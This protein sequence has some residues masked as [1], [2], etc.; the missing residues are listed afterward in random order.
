MVGGRVASRG[1]WRRRRFH[2][3]RLR[4]SSGRGRFDDAGG[5]L[6]H[7]RADLALEAAHAG[8]A[9]VLAD[10][11]RERRV[12]EG[13]VCRSD[14][15]FVELPR[16]E[17]APRDVKLLVLGVTDE[18]D[19]L[20]AIEQRRVNR[21]E[22]VRRGDEQHSRE[23]EVDFEVVVAEGVVL[24][25]VEHFEQRRRRIALKAGA[26]LVDLVQH[27]HRVH[28]AGLFE[29]L[30]D[31]AGNGAD[32]GAAMAADLGLVTHA[33]ERDAHELAVHRARDRLPERG[34]ADARAVRRSRGSGL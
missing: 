13:H 5:D 4:R 31:A 33:A 17:I 22:L 29:R 23:I 9:G 8:F 18:G 7:D 2:R 25:R 10:D 27:E 1:R 28:R 21:A 15:V 6:A 11:A 12:L 26:E 16:H 24:G 34:L 20:H 3:R 30:H 32:V 19:D 14:A